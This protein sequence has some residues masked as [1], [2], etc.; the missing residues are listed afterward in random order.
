MKRA[1]DVVLSILLLVLLSPILL[2]AAILIAAD[3]GRPVLFRQRRVGLVG[4]RDARDERAMLR[5]DAL[6]RRRLEA[7]RPGRDP[8]Y[9]PNPCPLERGFVSAVI[10]DAGVTGACADVPARHSGPGYR[11]AA[12]NAFKAPFG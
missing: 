12:P 5:H 2:A 11:G 1:M 3:S 10:A 7:S 9:G 6:E 8:V 4:H